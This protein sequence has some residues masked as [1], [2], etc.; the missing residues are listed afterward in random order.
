MLDPL[1]ACTNQEDTSG[2]TTSDAVDA[3]AQRIVLNHRYYTDVSLDEDS[4]HTFGYF[5]MATKEDF[6]VGDFPGSVV[7]II[8]YQHDEDNHPP[9]KKKE[10]VGDLV[11]DGSPDESLVV[12]QLVA[13]LALPPKTVPASFNPPTGAGI[14][15]EMVAKGSI[16]QK[17]R[18]DKLGPVAGEH[19][20]EFVLVM[21]GTAGTAS[22]VAMS[23]DTGSSLGNL[24]DFLYG[25]GVNHEFSP[26]VRVLVDRQLHT[27]MHHLP[28][29]Y[30]LSVSAARY[31]H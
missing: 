20:G 27:H 25:C 18:G 11:E 19:A 7:T 24:R 22:G 29:A 26:V 17:K 9:P 14:V 21:E 28:S 15:E 10:K 5:N 4:T 12:T 16:F 2:K 30:R 31:L 3:P 1:F 8:R 6:D 13:L 23:W